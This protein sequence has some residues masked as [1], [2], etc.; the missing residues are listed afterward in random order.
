MRTLSFLFNGIVSCTSIGRGHELAF[1][2]NDPQLSLEEYGVRTYDNLIIF[3]PQKK[4]GKLS[5]TDLLNFVETG[6]NIL[7]SSR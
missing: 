7:L 4:L 5:K 2:S 3:S 1:F 6:G